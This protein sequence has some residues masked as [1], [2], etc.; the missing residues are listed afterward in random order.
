VPDPERWFEY[1]AN[2]MMA[3]LLLPIPQVI[4]CIGD[5]YLQRDR[6]RRL[7]RRD[8]VLLAE[9]LSQTFDVM[10]QSVLPSCF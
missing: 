4:A 1:Q 8:R 9:E 10:P 2:R 3:S 5:Q 6:Y 7:S